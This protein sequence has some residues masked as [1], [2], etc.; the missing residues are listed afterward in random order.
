MYLIS[1]TNT[2]S[3][4]GRS[5][6]EIVGVLAIVGVL[7]IGGIIGYNYGMDKYRANQAINDISLRGID[8]VSKTQNGEDITEDDLDRMWQNEETLYPTFFF[9]EEEYDR[10][11]IQITGV[12]SHVCR[13]IGDGVADHIETRIAVEGE[14]HEI[15]EHI[16]EC[17]LSNDNTMFFFFEERHCVPECYD[18][19]RC[20]DGKCYGAEC[21]T[22]DDCN[23]GYT[24]TACSIC[25]NGSCK[26]GWDVNGK[27]CIFDDGR[28]GQCNN[29]TCVPKTEGGCTYDTN[30]CP[31]GS[32]CASPNTSESEA[33]PGDERGSCVEP[34]FDKYTINVNGTIETW[35]LSED[36]L[37]YWDAV[38]ACETKD[39]VMLPVTDWVNDWNFTMG[40]YTRNERAKALNTA[41]DGD[42]YSQWPSVWTTTS[43]D[44][45]NVF[46][47]DL[48][49]DKDR[50]GGNNVSWAGR[51]EAKY[52]NAACKEFDGTKAQ[53]TYNINPCPS[54]FYCTASN[55]SNDMAFQSGETGACVKPQF[56]THVISVDGVSETWYVSKSP[57]S[58]WDAKAACAAKNLTMVSSGE[59]VVGWSG[60]KGRFDFNARATE[61][62]QKEYVTVWTQ[63]KEGANEPNQGR[64]AFFVSFN[65][66]FSNNVD[67]WTKKDSKFHAL[68]R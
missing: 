1:A 15:H 19:E 50:W 54:G 10:F 26:P 57:L 18:N 42:V 32:Y 12:S 5:M 65:G 43:Q 33:F 68:C 28:L 29:T 44:D 53:C 55:T 39:L 31:I 16:E 59:L 24:G 63:Q 38:A 51:N 7:S 11:G 27:E 14:E 3:E 49:T 6:V 64:S 61:L 8:I 2:T 56:N 62:M 40:N 34:R 52:Y 17:D 48:T 30:V 58:W 9:Y 21:E 35:Y 66:A 46:I 25:Q 60:S 23:Q 47:V 13:L 45:Q 36:M 22:T 41:A 67:S 37:S 20:I 4:Q